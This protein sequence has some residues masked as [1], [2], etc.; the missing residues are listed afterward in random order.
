MAEQ[1]AVN[2]PG[3]EMLGS[4]GGTPRNARGRHIRV[5]INCL[6]MDSSY[7]GGVTTYVLG[8]LKGFAAAGKGT[9]FRIYVTPTNQGL[10]E[11]FREV[12]NFEIAVIGDSWLSLKRMVCR[13]ILLTDSQDLYKFTCDSVFR[14]VQRKME[15]ESDILYTPTVVLE[16]FDNRKPTVLSMHDIQH[17]HHPEFFGWARRTSRKITYGLSARHATYLQASSEYIKRDL[18][19]NFSWLSEEQIE[20]IPSGALIERFAI[21]AP[22]EALSRYALPHRFLFFPAQLWPHKNHVTVLKALKLIEIQQGVKIP[23]ILTGEKFSAAA[24]IFKFVAD[25]SMDYVRYLG[26]VPVADMVALYQ[27]A[28]FVLTATLHESSSLPIL[29]A[30]AAGTPVI[31][32]RIPPIEELGQVL[33]LNFFDPLDVNALARLIWELWRDEKIPSAQAAHNREHIAV[34]SWANTA[35]KYVTLF[36]RITSSSFACGKADNLQDDP[37]TEVS[38]V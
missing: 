23:L 38:S 28:V 33:Q 31:C 34:Y 22:L 37:K 9:S 21:P 7:A 8:L 24:G 30:A 36:E 32:S 20:V 27:N 15:A 4:L 16:C 11:E 12:D 26:K 1:I 17:L 13:G 19:E 5:G 35:R 14:K 18:L 3:T 25:Q 6:R 29:E 2:N 10:F